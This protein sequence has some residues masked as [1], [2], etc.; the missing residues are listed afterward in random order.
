[1]MKKVTSKFNKIGVIVIICFSLLQGFSQECKQTQDNYNWEKI[2]PLVTKEADVQKFYGEPTLV[3]G[4]SKIYQTDFGGIVVLYNGGKDTEKP[5]CESDK[6]SPDNVYDFLIT[7]TKP[8]QL[9][10]LKYDLKY[11]LTNYESK[12][13]ER[14]PSDSGTIEYLNTKKG[15]RFITHFDDESGE[16]LVTRIHYFPSES[17]LKNNCNKIN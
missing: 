13:Y 5:I 3:M 10:E 15:I 12:N 17:D 16:E 11:D 6:V 4:Y 9:S 2:I 14:I 7:L 8:I 1:M